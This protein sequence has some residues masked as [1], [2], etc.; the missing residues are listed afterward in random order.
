MKPERK[1]RGFR[2]IEGAA[3]ALDPGV[4]KT[5]SDRAA[6]HSIY[7]LPAFLK[8]EIIKNP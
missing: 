6:K 5:I 7:F 2:K 8:K 4:F 1:K 3:A